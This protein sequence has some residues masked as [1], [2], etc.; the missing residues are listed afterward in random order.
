M[1]PE[2]T[3]WSSERSV[4]FHRNLVVP[5]RFKGEGARDVVTVLPK[6]DEVIIPH[7]RYA[8]SITGGIFTLCFNQQPRGDLGIQRIVTL[9]YCWVIPTGS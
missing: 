3:T 1:S 8:V 4:M 5:P 2:L 7:K 6:G 9:P